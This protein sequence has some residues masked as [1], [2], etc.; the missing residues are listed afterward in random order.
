MMLSSVAFGQDEYIDIQDFEF[1]RG[2][3]DSSVSEIPC[4][5]VQD[6]TSHQ[7]KG[8]YIVFRKV[9]DGYTPYDYVNA[10]SE[11]GA[12]FLTTGKFCAVGLDADGEASTHKHFFEITEEHCEYGYSS[13]KKAP[14][15][16]L[17]GI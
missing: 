14:P 15:I 6:I 4:L 17:I 9:S 7:K 1:Y 16:V 11:F 2:V 3:K 10:G 12:K 13:D 5:F 8:T